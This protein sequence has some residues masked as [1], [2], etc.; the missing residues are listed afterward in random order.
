[1]CLGNFL[2]YASG[3]HDQG[4]RVKDELHLSL[5]RCT[6]PSYK[7]TKN[8]WYRCTK[9]SSTSVPGTAPRVQWPASDL[10]DKAGR[11]DI[12]RLCYAHNA[13]SDY[14]RG[15]GCRCPDRQKGVGQ[16]WN[17]TSSLP[18]NNPL[19]EAD[20]RV[21]LFEKPCLVWRQPTEA[22]EPWCARLTSYL[23]RPRRPGHAGRL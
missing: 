13:A 6:Y 5:F 14:D 15:S 8:S 19:I 1:M 17:G 9:A 2:A 21:S 22:S 11:D 4:L 18:W 23:H 12:K 10:R 16:R 3:Y 20:P 7:V